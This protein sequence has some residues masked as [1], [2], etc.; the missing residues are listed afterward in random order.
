MT[1]RAITID[2]WGTLLFDSPASDNRYK[3]R[4]MKDFE[5]I[6]AG[7]GVRVSASALDRAYEASGSYLGRIWARHRDV[8]VEDHVRAIVGAIDGDLAARLPA[9]LLAALVDAYARP[10][11]AVPPTVDDGASKALRT[12][13]GLGYTLAVV[14]NT[15]RT[16]GSTLRT[17]LEQFQILECFD[18]LV[19]SDEIGIRKPR[20]EI[21]LDALSA[22]GGEPATT[23]HVGDDPVLDV[24]GGRAVGCKTIQVVGN[25]SGAAPTAER[26]D[27]TISRFEE[28]P[29][30][31]QAFEAR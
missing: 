28:L 26:A 23:V 3:T 31:I 4:R 11:L 7:A 14:S 27:R 9:D 10:I 1:V 30:A 24:Q 25:G 18:Y 2:F 21:F 15:M 29:A 13:C 22:V 6:L 5:T 17:V 16:P 20:P 8:G 12:L 19:F